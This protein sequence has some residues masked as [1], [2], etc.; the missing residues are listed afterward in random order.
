MSFEWYRDFVDVGYV[1][2]A[3]E[4][5]AFFKY[6]PTSGMLPI[7]AVGRLASE[8]SIGTWTTLSLLSKRIKKLMARVYKYDDSHAYIAYPK[9]LWEPGS[10]PQLMSGIGG[11]IFGMKAVES[12]R[13]VD[14]ELPSWFIK[15]FY[16]PTHG[17]GV[18]KTIFKRK[19]GPITA[20]VPKPKLGF[21]SKEH[22]EV[23]FNLW[24]GGLDCVKD[25]ENLTSQ[26]FNKFNDRVKLLSKAR[27][28]AEKLTGDVKE[29]F[30]N[31][32][33]PN[34]K[35][36]EKRVD[37]IHAHGF[38]YFMIDVVISGF[39]A[40][41]T[42]AELARERKMAIHAHRAMHAM[43]TRSPMHGM[44]MYF[45]AKLCRLMGVDQIHTGTVIGKLE[46]DKSEIMAMRDMLLKQRVDVVPEICMA[47]SFGKIKP[48]LPVVSG[49]LHPG[50]L[51]EV[52]RIY[53]TDS[54]VLQVGGGVM[55]H[56]DGVYAGARAVYDA[57]EAYHN[58]YSLE[59]YAKKSKYLAKAL[60]KW[61]H[62][63]P[64]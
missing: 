48:V 46:G 31:V 30:I 28:K 9:E 21:T 55:G 17:V 4:I 37:L 44:S 13:L 18:I 50:I 33:A 35:E 53:G 38:R 61:G 7:D 58:G 1:P 26:S 6:K 51:P 23:A 32:T 60:Q 43:M 24:T 22:T 40:V 64:V 52:M 19:R 11:N 3:D 15:S 63:K 16:G 27:D 57:I 49:G 47:Q 25:D 42:A 10:V 34:F 62:A 14:A 54:I 56:P 39:T 12:L 45:L 8:S 2:R 29:A 5:K 59:E 20:T 36:L 41:K